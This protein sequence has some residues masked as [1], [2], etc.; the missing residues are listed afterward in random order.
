MDRLKELKKG[1]AAPEDISISIA[2][3]EN[4][5]V[6]LVNANKAK[7]AN[8]A[9]SGGGGEFMHEFFARAETVKTNINVIKDSTRDIAEINQ[10]VVQ[11]TTSDREHEFSNLLE[12]LVK[13][14]NKCATAAKTTLTSLREETDRMKQE[15]QA[16]NN[17][18]TPE[19]RIRDNLV[20][21]LTRK[22]V[23][24]MKEYQNAQTKYK[25]EIKKK[26]KRQVQIVKPDATME[27]IDAVF[28]SGGGASEVLKTAI[29]TGEAADS[30]QNAFQN[31]ADKY[32]DVLT[33]EASVAEL[34]QMFLDF[35]LLTEKQGELLDQIEHQ[36]KEASDY[37]DAGNEEM[38]QAIEI[39]KS[40]RRKQCLIAIIVLIVIAIVAGLV[41]AKAQ[42]KI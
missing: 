17:K 14:T 6:G 9:N 7:G 32:Q 21:T 19:I 25:T 11:A 23:E 10:N 12:P 24:V 28:K 42:G 41:A 30:I 37:I 29:L 3:T 34:H 35:A 22:F 39:Q 33:L 8:A 16:N 31:A 5:R 26:V 38:V 1:A 13:K 27:E 4:D 20:N 36:V 2:D 15:A 18:Q 40:I